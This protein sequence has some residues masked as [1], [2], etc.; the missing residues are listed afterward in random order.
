VTYDC[1]AR[2]RSESIINY[3]ERNDFSLLV[4]LGRLSVPIIMLRRMTMNNELERIRKEVV[5]N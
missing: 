2:K 4:C 3:W 1:R 5:V